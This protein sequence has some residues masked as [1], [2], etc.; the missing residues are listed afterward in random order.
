VGLDSRLSGSDPEL[1]L[2]TPL[3]NLWPFDEKGIAKEAERW[4]ADR[5]YRQCA[6]GEVLVFSRI[7]CWA[8]R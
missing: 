1:V 7:G 4:S 2:L 3:G 8:A 6:A 5:R